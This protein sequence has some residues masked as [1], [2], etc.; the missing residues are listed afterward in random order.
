MRS[1]TRSRPSSKESDSSSAATSI[2]DNLDARTV[3]KTYKLI[4]EFAAVCSFTL[5]A[6]FTK[7]I[8]LPEAVELTTE[9]RALFA[10]VHWDS[11]KGEYGTVRES[12]TGEQ[13]ISGISYKRF[14]SLVEGA[15]PA[16]LPEGIT[17]TPQSILPTPRQGQT[18][19]NKQ[20]KSCPKCG[21]SV[22][23][24]FSRCNGTPPTARHQ[25][26]RKSDA[27]S[28]KERKVNN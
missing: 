24:T 27:G 21:S 11:V 9:V 26:A 25:G 1:P 8:T 14:H 15:K 18:P 12:L 19:V 4:V 3:E 17:H 23:H 2:C 28:Q 6:T 13:I 20:K 7:S 16:L 10:P 22:Y 5:S